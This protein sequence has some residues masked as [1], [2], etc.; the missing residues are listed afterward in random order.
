MNSSFI[1]NT[2]N[3]WLFLEYPSL[4]KFCNPGSIQTLDI[5]AL[6]QDK[7]WK[8]TGKKNIQPF[9]SYF[10]LS[11]LRLLWK[12]LDFINSKNKA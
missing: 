8:K 10:Q 4:F 6:R 7:R 3:F 12:S 1:G 9:P 5:L 2:G 11:E